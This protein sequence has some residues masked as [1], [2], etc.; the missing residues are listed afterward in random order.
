MHGMCILVYLFI[1]NS[2]TSKCIFFIF[3]YLYIFCYLC[4]GVIIIIIGEINNNSPP[5]LY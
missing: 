1:F 3:V 4:Y 5:L 2:H